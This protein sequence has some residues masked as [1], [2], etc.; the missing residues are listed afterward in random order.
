MGEFTPQRPVLQSFVGNIRQAD[1]NVYF[2]GSDTDLA[3]G[4]MWGPV[5]RDHYLLQYCTRGRGVV[6]LDNIPYPLEMGQCI[7]CFPNQTILEEADQE[8]PWSLSWVGLKGLLL[9][10]YLQRMGRSERSPV[11]PWRNSEYI[12]HCFNRVIA[13]GEP[14]PDPSRAGGSLDSRREDELHADL[15]G[16]L[17]RLACVYSILS[18]SYRLCSQSKELG[19]TRVEQDDYIRKAVAYIEANYNQKIHIS[20][21]ARHVGLNR[22]YLFTLFKENMNQSPQDFLTQL[23]IKK[24]C[25]FFRNPQA[26]VASVAD[27]LGY[28]PRALTRLFKQITGYTPSQYRRMLQE[29]DA[30]RE[31][32][33]Q[34]DS[35]R[36]A[37]LDF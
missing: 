28:E 15:G 25:D 26:T 7:V 16:E 6:Y 34:T 35:G 11:F 29:S 27:S 3:P 23:R 10:Y 19:I 4:H 24:A 33:E 5:I 32:S 22:S 30:P 37:A 13:S 17:E 20:D 18:E 1:L 8:D 2:W 36:S 14:I 31:L 21:V 12:L 9:P